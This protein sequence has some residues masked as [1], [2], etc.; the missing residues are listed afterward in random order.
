MFS[1]IKVVVCDLDGT[2][3]VTRQPM[4]Q[5][6]KQAIRTLREKGY[7]FGIASGRNI[8]DLKSMMKTW[9]IEENEYDFIVGLNGSELWDGIHDK[10]HTYFQMKPEWIQETFEI[11][12][13]F[14]HNPVMYFGRAFMVGHYNLDVAFSAQ[15]TKSDY[16]I[17]TCEEDFYQEPNA[18]IMFRVD[19]SIMPEVEKRCKEMESPYYSANKTKST[20]MEFQNRNATKA[21]AL[22]QF[23]VLNGMTLENVIAFGD[24]TNDNDMLEKAGIGV[25]MINGSEDT[26]AISDIITN[27]PVEEDGWADFIEN[28]FLG[29]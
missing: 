28:T 26:K 2:L 24:T 3:V 23:C 4:S 9:G 20:L 6:G 27:L 18:K 15:Y 22:E 19:E 13:P 25:C 8:G 29:K 21:Y 14:E 16:T 10:V 12:R 11:M 1:K 7:I 5:R 17:A